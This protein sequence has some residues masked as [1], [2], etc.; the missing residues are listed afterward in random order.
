MCRI[1]YNLVKLLLG[2]NK[3][4][5]N[6][7]LQ[8]LD[9]FR[10]V[11][12]PDRCWFCNEVIE[13]KTDLCISCKEN[14]KRI[15]GNRCL[16][17]GMAESFCDCKGKSHFYDG[18]TAPYMY[19][20]LVRRGILRW[21]YYDNVHAVKFFAK[22]T[23]KCI[24][25]DFS[26]VKFD[27][28]TYIPQTKN[29]EDEK[30]QNQSE[31][32]AKEI[33]KYLKIPCEQLLEKI[34]ETTR[35]HDLPMH[36]RYGNVFG[37]FGCTNKSTVTGKTILLIDDVKTSGNTLNECAKVLQLNDATAVYCAVIAVAENKKSK[38]K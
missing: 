31:L 38:K 25:N 21:K 18:I 10:A 9:K 22:E 1:L 34:F 36:M 29:E 35:Q 4:L 19:N 8:E 33:S 37:V 30:G 7:I 13:Y 6:D 28:I 26:S 24:I 11:F 17:C 12:Y 27:V 2:G 23:V 14:V 20:E 32:L 15:S 5:K 16:N 3:M